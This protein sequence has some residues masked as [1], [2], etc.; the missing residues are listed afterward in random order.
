VIKIPKTP[1][2]RFITENYRTSGVSSSV[3]YCCLF[4]LL[5]TIQQEYAVYNENACSSKG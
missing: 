2:T 4:T 3:G 5:Q 1:S